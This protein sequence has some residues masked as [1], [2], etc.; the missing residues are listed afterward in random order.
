M[1]TGSTRGGAFHTTG[2]VAKL[3]RVTKR[4]VI[5]W[6]ESGRLRGFRLP[7][8]THRRVAAADLAAFLKAHRIPLPAD[9]SLRRRILV[10]DDDP[11]FVELLV[12]A[13]S[14]RYDVQTARNAL[15]AASRLPV[16]GPDLVLLDVRLPDV[17]GLEVCR[18]FQPWR[19]SADG[20]IV[21]MSAY[22][23]EL[24]P[25]EIRRSGADGFLAKPVRL[26]DLRKR[27]QTLVG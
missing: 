25:G 4:T 1:T 21:V 15:E 6:I 16:F 24:D 2:Q 27:I 10:V 14:D 11:D 22:G 7:G 3:C 19:R 20:R 9:P 18:H 23:N 17:G 8:S 26:A 13:L 12:D 5:K